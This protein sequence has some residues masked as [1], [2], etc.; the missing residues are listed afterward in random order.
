MTRRHEAQDSPRA[1]HPVPGVAG[2]PGYGGSGLPS[3]SHLQTHRGLKGGWRQGSLGHWD[4]EAPW[5]QG[6]VPALRPA[7]PGDQP[8]ALSCLKPWVPLSDSPAQGHL[9]HLKEAVH[10]LCGR[11]RGRG[12]G[13][14]GPQAGPSCTRTP[15]QADLWQS[16]P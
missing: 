8:G 9:W 6:L 13:D 1:A 3:C 4:L 14:R 11:C 5:G 10:E 2:P 15:S 7:R 12:T 16:S